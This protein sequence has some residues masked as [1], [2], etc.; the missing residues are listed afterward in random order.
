MDATSNTYLGLKD[1]ISPSGDQYFVR[2]GW[3]LDATTLMPIGV[4]ADY[5]SSAWSI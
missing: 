4:T 5:S 3:I 2:Y 1:I